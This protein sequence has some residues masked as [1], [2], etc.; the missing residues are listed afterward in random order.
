MNPPLQQFAS[1]NYS[2]MCPE[3][4]EYLLAAN[5]GDAPAYGNDQWTQRVADRF[6]ET[7]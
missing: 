3:A 2:G 4:V 1:D 6:R 7:F 5:I